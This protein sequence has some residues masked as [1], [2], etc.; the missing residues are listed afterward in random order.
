MLEMGKWDRKPAAT[1]ALHTSLGRE[2]VDQRPLQGGLRIMSN[3]VS[4]IRILVVDDHPV[5][6]DGLASMIESQDDMELIGEAE[7]GQQAITL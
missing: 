7:N 5:V 6:R 2:K 1:C 4:K 3:K